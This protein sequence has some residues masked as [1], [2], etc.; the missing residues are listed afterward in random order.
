[1]VETFVTQFG[2]PES[3]HSD[4]GR[5]FESDVFNK[6]VRLLGAHHTRSSP[7]L[8]HISRQ[9]ERYNHTLRT[10][11]ALNVEDSQETWDETLPL[12]MMAYQSTIQES[13]GETPNRVFLG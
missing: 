8:P 13:T 4:Q 3:T 7:Y 11:L 6:T 12:V 1:M 9:V 5:Q 10:M 2:L